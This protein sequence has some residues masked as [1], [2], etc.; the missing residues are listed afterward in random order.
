GGFEGAEEIIEGAAE[1]FTE[2]GDPS[3]L[4]PLA[5]RLAREAFQ[6][7]YQ[8]QSRWPEV[9]D[10]DRLDAAFAE[11]ERD[12]VVCRQNFSCCGNC[13]C[14]EIGAEME[15]VRSAGRGVL[16]YAFYHMQDTESAAE[17][18]GLCLNYG[19]TE[20]GEG[21]AVRIGRQIVAVL[22]RHGL[23]TEWDGSWSKRI[24]I[25]MDWKRRRPVEIV[26]PSG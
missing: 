25:R 20:G 23:R 12:G 1:V 24:Q 15:E 3:D 9:T 14:A 4:R 13:G 11:L 22:N 10:C 5:E 7:H 2:G 17:G 26:R 16:G 18:Y 6:A 19:A 21:P 8:E